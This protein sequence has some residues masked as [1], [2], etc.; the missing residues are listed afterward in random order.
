[1][2]TPDK[3]RFLYNQTDIENGKRKTKIILHLYQKLRN[4]AAGF[5]HLVSDFCVCFSTGDAQAYLHN[6]TSICSL[7]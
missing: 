7:I 2:N 6:T 1:M 3:K 4:C 5:F